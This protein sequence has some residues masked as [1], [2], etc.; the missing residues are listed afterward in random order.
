MAKVTWTRRAADDAP[1]SASRR[2]RVSID[3]RGHGRPLNAISKSMQM[4]LA[5][6]VRT[7]LAEWLLARSAGGQEHAAGAVPPRSEDAITKVTL[8]MPARHAAGLA[9]AARAAELS[10]GIYVARLLDGQQP[11]PVAPDQHENRLALL[12]S[13]AMLAALSSDLHALLRAM[14]QASSPEPAACNAAVDELSDAVQ[15]HLAAAA[16]LMAAMAPSRRP[17]A[18]DPA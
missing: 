17:G 5:A 18:G 16:P 3:L 1:R 13:T 6:L 12:R 11:A 8:R 7:I 15:Q 10:Q 2:E 14:R 4:P 9:R